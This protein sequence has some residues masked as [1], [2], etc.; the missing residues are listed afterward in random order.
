MNETLI[1]HVC[2]GGAWRA[3]QGGDA[4]AG[5][6]DDL[7]DGYMHFSTYSQVRTSVALH[8][9]GQAGLLML[10]VEMAKLGS[11]LKWEASR[12]GQ[13]FPHLFGTLPRDAV[14][15]VID[16]PLGD[17]GAHQFP[18]DYPGLEEGPRKTSH[19]HRRDRR[20]RLLA[21]NGQ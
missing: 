18:D 2:D 17:D 8:R 4:Y 14:I 1:Y 5:S 10:V 12:G 16:L 15:E 13:L 11:S 20:D 6:P 7:R 9:A 21:S 19:G 3:A